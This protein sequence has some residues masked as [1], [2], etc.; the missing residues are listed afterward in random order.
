[1]FDVRLMSVLGSLERQREPGHLEYAHKNHA[2]SDKGIFLV[3]AVAA[4]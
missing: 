1:M 4:H 2:Y 3:A